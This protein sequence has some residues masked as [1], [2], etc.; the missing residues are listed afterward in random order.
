ML[1]PTQR[2]IAQVFD[3]R[4]ECDTA[5]ICLSRQ[6]E[7][8]RALCSHIQLEANRFEDLLTQVRLHQFAHIFFQPTLVQRADLVA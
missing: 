1:R 7:Y 5:L 2:D 6:I 8:C 4:V 3:R